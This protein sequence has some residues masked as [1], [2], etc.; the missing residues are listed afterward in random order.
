MKALLSALAAAAVLSTATIAFAADP[1][2]PAD[3]KDSGSLSS[4]A[5]DASPATKDQ[6]ENAPVGNDASS[7]ASTGDAGSDTL[8]GTKKPMSSDPA[9]TKKN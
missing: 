3:K 5:K 4:G 1:A 8:P 6:G 2:G 7:G 9:G